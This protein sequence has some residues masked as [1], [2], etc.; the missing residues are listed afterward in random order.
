MEP[1]DHCLSTPEMQIP[2]KIPTSLYTFLDV[3]LMTLL[4]S[5][6]HFPQ[7]FLS[8]RLIHSNMLFLFTL[9]KI[10][11]L[12]LI[13]QDSLIELNTCL[14]CLCA[15]ANA[16]MRAYYNCREVVV[17][18]VHSHFSVVLYHT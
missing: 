8:R 10:Q 4:S 3:H 1:E 6:A 17:K 14:Y 15:H 16:V 9:V 13:Y 2:T 7:M 12:S 5:L 11:T 18:C